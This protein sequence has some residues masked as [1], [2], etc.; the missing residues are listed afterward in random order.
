MAR[1]RRRPWGPWKPGLRRN[2][3]QRPPWCWALDGSPRPPW[4]ASPTWARQGLKATFPRRSRWSP[5]RPESA[6]FTAVPAHSPEHLGVGSEGS[7]AVS[8]TCQEVS[9]DQCL[10]IS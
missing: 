9:H 7:Q 1:E 2:V 10:F 3:H 6:P 8:V 4:P 5:A